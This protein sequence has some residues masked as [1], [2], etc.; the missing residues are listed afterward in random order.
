MH[1]TSRACGR[2]RCSVHT[3]AVTHHHLTLSCRGSRAG[4]GEA[5]KQSSWWPTCSGEKLHEKLVLAAALLLNQSE[6][7]PDHGPN[8]RRSR[9]SL[10]W[11]R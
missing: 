1:A 10:A 4:F 2:G 5:R 11:A 6:L 3:P 9:D 7:G 8:R